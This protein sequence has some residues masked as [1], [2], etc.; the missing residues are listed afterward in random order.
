MPPHRHRHR[1]SA[2]RPACG[3]HARSRSRRVDA[4]GSRRRPADPAE[5]LREPRLPGVSRRRSRRGRQVHRP[6]AGATRRSSR[7]MPSLELENT[8]CRWPRPGLERRRAFR[9]MPNARR[10]WAMTLA[11]FAT[12]DA[13]AYRFAVTERKAGRAPEVEN[14]TCWSGSAAS[15]A[16]SMPWA[17]GAFR[18]SPHAEPR[19]PGHEP[20]GW[21]LHTT[22]CRLM[23]CLP[24]AAWS[25]T[26]RSNACDTRLRLAGTIAHAAPARRLPPRQHLQDAAGPHFVD[27]DDALTGPAVRDLWMLLSG[28]RATPAPARRGARR[29]RGSSWTS[30]AASSR[31]SEPAAHAAHRAPQCVDRTALEGPGLCR[32]PWFRKPGSLD[33]PVTRLRDQLEAMEEEA[34]GRLNA[35]RAQPASSALTRFT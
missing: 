12:P 19:Q 26:P 18:A 29:L 17:H 5:L 2:R 27:P 13:G 31:S 15:S 14:P 30:T 6:G 33:R 35:V 34:A 8:R 32:L 20:R 23:R 25:M 11:H 4:V 10:A 28:N 3:A 7:S 1:R 21:L 22:S 9:C 16:A 24:G